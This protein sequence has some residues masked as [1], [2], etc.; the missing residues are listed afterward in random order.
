MK[1]LL[2]RLAY[3]DCNKILRPQIHGEKCAQLE[4]IKAARKVHSC[5]SG[6]EFHLSACKIN[7]FQCKRRLNYFKIE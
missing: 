6:D 2:K 4:T 3:D 7:T 5:K 1:T